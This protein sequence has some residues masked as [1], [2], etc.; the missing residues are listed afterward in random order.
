MNRKWGEG[1]EAVVRS[2]A[3][4]WIKAFPDDYPHTDQA[5]ALM[6]QVGLGVREVLGQGWH[7][8]AA[9]MHQVGRY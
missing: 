1:V 3:A 5:V 4:A 6:D 2:S 8:T 9:L 7:M